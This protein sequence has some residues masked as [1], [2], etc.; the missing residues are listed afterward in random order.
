MKK[1]E[2]TGGTP[3]VIKNDFGGK[4]YII[5]SRKYAKP[6]DIKFPELVIIECENKNGRKLLLVEAEG[7]GEK[8][9][10]V[11]EDHGR[12]IPLNEIRG[13]YEMGLGCSFGEL[14]KVV[15]QQRYVLVV[16]CN[17][18]YSVNHW[19]PVAYDFEDTT[20]L[21]QMHEEWQE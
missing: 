8:H 4:D 7:V 17:D 21:R 1:K 11:I 9:L 19:V 10:K 6:G 3:F 13:I 18:K 5:L 12:A 16:D 15:K 14:K 2:H 20:C